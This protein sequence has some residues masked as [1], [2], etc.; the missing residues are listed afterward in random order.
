MKLIDKK[1][2]AIAVLDVDNKTFVVYVAALDI[3]GTNK[4]IHL[5]WIV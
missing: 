3:E 2:F 5:S 4:A 1:E